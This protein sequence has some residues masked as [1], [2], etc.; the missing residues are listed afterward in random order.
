MFLP[1]FKHDLYHALL[2]SLCIHYL[3]SSKILFYVKNV[4][5]NWPKTSFTFFASNSIAMSKYES[6]MVDLVN[7]KLLPERSSNSMKKSKILN[8]RVNSLTTKIFKKIQEKVN[9]KW[10]IRDISCVPQK[11]VALNIRMPYTQDIQLSYSKTVP[12]HTLKN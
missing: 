10:T 4:F 7:S 6:D 2:L 12:R 11:M 5:F 8:P 3:T 9:L 1:L